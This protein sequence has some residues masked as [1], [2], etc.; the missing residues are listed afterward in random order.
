MTQTLVK[1]EAQQ[2][3]VQQQQNQHAGSNEVQEHHA[4]ANASAGLNLNLFGALSGALSS[5]SKKTT[6]QN[7]DGSST[8]T[9]DRHDQAGANGV[10]AGQGKAY[11]TGKAQERSLKSSERG[12]G[13]EVSQGKKSVVKGSKTVDHLGL[14]A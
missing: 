9:E 10:A 7:A 1:K 6:Y 2:Q 5:K 4:S 12:V 13:Q 14:E 8:T 3:Q 11:A